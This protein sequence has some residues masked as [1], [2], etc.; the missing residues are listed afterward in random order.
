MTR[1]VLLLQT[2]FLLLSPG[3]VH[4]QQRAFRV[5][6]QATCETCRLTV[7]PLVQ[8]GSLSDP[9]GF[10]PTVQVAVNA[11]NDYLVSSG[12]FVGEIQKYGANGRFAGTI[13]RQ[14]G[15]PGEFNREVL[16]AFDRNDSL[17]VVEKGGTR[18]SVFSPALEHV[19]SAKLPFPVTDFCMATGRRIVAIAPRYRTAPSRLAGS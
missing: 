3:G 8:L 9:A 17:H 11:R 2:A 16:L 4:A 7:E 10:G 5:G 15:G 13:A 1:R 18:Y 6:D 12:T 14:G 19:R